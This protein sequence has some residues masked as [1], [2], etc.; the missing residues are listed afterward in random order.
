VPNL[1]IATFN[2][3]GIRSRLPTLLTWLREVSPDIVCL[4]ELKATDS[5][6]PVAA[7]NDTGYGAIWHGQS[8]WNGVAILARDADPIETRRGLPGDRSD[9]QSR[10]LEVAVSGLLIGCLYLPNGNPQPGPKFDYKLAWFARLDIAILPVRKRRA[11][12]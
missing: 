1:K 11:S 2:I 7:I 6:F 9:R 4:Q 5:A 12:F 3:N 10:Y 8:A